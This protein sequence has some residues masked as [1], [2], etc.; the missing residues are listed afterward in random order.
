[1]NKLY[2]YRVFNGFEKKIIEDSLLYFA[3]VEDFNDPFDSKLSFQE[4]YPIQEIKNYFSAVKLRNPDA[5]FKWEDLKK[6]YGKKMIL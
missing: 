6:K 2:K 4:D 5:P 1:M 3:S